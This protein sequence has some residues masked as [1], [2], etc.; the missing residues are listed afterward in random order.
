LADQRQ[1]LNRREIIEADAQRAASRLDP[2]RTRDRTQL[3]A[4]VSALANEAGI[5]NLN[6]QSQPSVTTGQF[7]IH[8]LNVTAT[9]VEWEALRK[10]YTGLQ[11]KAPYIGIDRIA[12]TANPANRSH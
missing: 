7:S 6:S 8:R 9:N 2:A 11:S 5:R 12:I 3:L 4:E 10:F 1:W